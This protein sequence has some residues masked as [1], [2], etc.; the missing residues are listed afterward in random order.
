[1]ADRIVVLQEGKL[2]EHGTH[3]ELLA[4]Q[5]QYSELFQLQAAGYR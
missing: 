4:A 5:G 3:E 2:L 1:M